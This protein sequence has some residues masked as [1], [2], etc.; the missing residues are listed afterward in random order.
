MNKEELQELIDEGREIEFIYKGIKYSITYY[1]DSR[2]NFISFCEFFKE[3]IDVSSVDEL[4]EIVI[5]GERLEEILNS[6]TD[7]YIWIF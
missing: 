2:E 5:D 1:Y 7:D 4:L 6:L 3:P